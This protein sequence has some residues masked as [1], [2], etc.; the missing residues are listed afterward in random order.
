MI[1]FGPIVVETFKIGDLNNT[2]WF[3]V[4]RWA[5]A[6][7]WAVS[8]A[9]AW[10]VAVLTVYASPNKVD[11]FNPDEGAKTIGPGTAA[12]VTLDVSGYHWI[13][14]RV[15]TAEGADDYVTLYVTGKT[16]E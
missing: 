12:T 8:G 4:S 7:I 15:T 6:K 9:A 16:N 10:G 1:P 5:T 13:G 3:D 2:A 14:V 11:V